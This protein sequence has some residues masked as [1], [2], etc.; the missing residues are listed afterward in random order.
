MNGSAA[1]RQ[2]Q[3]LRVL[4]LFAVALTVLPL[5]AASAHTSSQNRTVRVHSGTI[6]V[7]AYGEQGHNYHI[8][9]TTV[10]WD[11]CRQVLHRDA[12]HIGHHA[13]WYA[14]GRY[15]AYMDP[16]YST[17]SWYSHQTSITEDVW[18]LGC[19]NGPGVN[20]TITMDTWNYARHIN[21]WYPPYGGPGVRP[22][23]SH[24]PLPLSEQRDV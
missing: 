16:V 24:C 7:D 13:K 4:G 15:C 21:T 19:N 20:V 1:G 2:R 11:S 8:V 23:T 3:R 17:S 14:D 6:C 12:G 10:R 18:Y 5:Q 22:I 9:R